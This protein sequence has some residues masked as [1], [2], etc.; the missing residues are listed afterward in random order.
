M[1]STLPNGVAG[2]AY[3]QSLSSSGGIAPYTYS[4]VSGA[5]P[6]GIAFSSAGTLSGTPVLAGNYSFTV[7][8]T[9]DAGYNRTIGYSIV[10]ADAVPGVKVVDTTGA[11]DA[12]AAGFLFA[13]T[14]GR[15]LHAC[16]V[17]G[18]KLAAEVISHYGARAEA[19]LRALAAG[20]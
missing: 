5:L 18:G 11:G 12:Y 2:S 20:A 6:V 7:R 9:D 4:I 14:K 19:D 8:S 15:D 10:V 3:S 16:G 1:P 13:Y 17:L